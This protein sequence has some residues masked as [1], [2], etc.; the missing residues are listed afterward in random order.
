MLLGSV[1][2]N[3]K[4]NGW[5]RSTTKQQNKSFLI[6]L[7]T[8][9]FLLKRQ[10]EKYKYS[11]SWSHKLWKSL[12][13]NPI[14]L[15]FKAFVNPATGRYVW[16]DLAEC[17]VDYLNDSRWSTEMIA[18]S[19]FLLLLEGQTVHLPRIKNP[20]AIDMCIRRENTIP[21]FPTSKESIEFI[22]KYNIRDERESA[23]MSSRWYTFNFTHQIENAR[24]IDLALAVL[25][26]LC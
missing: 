18:W 20:Y 19:D 6:C 5:K 9:K 16:V 2:P 3:V 25:A 24:N 7:C 1:Q 14:E 8:K 26:N 11:N 13:L 4:E 22:G 10:T 15:M 12:L 17:K 23:M 21:F